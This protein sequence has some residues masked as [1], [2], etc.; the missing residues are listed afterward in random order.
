MYMTWKEFKKRALA[1]LND[2]R[3][4]FLEGEELDLSNAYIDYNK[5]NIAP[6]KSI[7]Y[8]KSQPPLIV[9]KLKVYLLY[10]RYVV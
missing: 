5:N 4:C 6:I 10:I 1:I 8:Y 7:F 9:L 3:S 2:D